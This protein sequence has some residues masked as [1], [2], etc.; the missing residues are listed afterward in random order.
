MTWKTYIRAHLSLSLVLLAACTTMQLPERDGVPQIDRGGA[1]QI[2]R[3]F[4]DGKRV[5]AVV[6]RVFTR[7][8]IINAKADS[9]YP[10]RLLEGWYRK[11]LD[12]GY[13]DSDIVNESGILAISYC[14]GHSTMSQCSFRGYYEVYVG[15]ELRGQLVPSRSVEIRGR[16]KYEHGDIVEIELQPTALGEF[17]AVVVGVHRKHDDWRDCRVRELENNPVEVLITWLFLLGPP[18]ARWVECDGLE[19]DGW[20]RVFVRGALQ[21][22]YEGRRAPPTQ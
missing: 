3:N 11:L 10:L 17:I 19:K 8:E 7:D 1:I 16:Q 5:L 6:E 15:A 22:I 18:Q 9:Q 4:V 14:Y 13:S 12:A 20:R 2:P 21:G